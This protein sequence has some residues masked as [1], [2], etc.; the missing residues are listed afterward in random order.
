M[1]RLYVSLIIFLVCVCVCFAGAFLV[2]DSSDKINRKADEVYALIKS[3]NGAATD[4]AN[5]LLDLWE[6]EQIKLIPF[7]PMKRID[8]ISLII[9]ALPQTVLEKDGA[10]E[11]ARI[12][13]MINDLYA[14]EGFNIYD[15]F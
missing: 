11:L 8:D 10:A 3:D 5:E 14:A 9:Y 12:K 2:K 15:L 13:F 6:K 4:K 7:T 1:S